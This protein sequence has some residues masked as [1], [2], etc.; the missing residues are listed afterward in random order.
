MKFLLTIVLLASFLVLSL[1]VVCIKDTCS[2]VRCRQVTFEQCSLNGLEY[3]QHGGYCGCCSAC[4]KLLSKS[5][6]L[7]IKFDK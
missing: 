1:A 3:E 5:N 7:T 2:R 4:I 6:N